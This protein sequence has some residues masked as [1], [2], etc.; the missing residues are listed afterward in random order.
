M[1]Y[2]WWD[3]ASI[4]NM[5]ESDIISESP[6]NCHL[7]DYQHPQLLSKNTAEEKIV[8]VNVKKVKKARKSCVPARHNRFSR[9]TLQSMITSFAP[10]KKSLTLVTFD[11]ALAVFEL[12]VSL[13]G[14]S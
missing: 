13:D 11:G 14:V 1:H 12:L 5:N 8:K 4:T 3:E 6:N 7:M 2:A 9:T 10:A